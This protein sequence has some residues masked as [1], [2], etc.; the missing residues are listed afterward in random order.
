MPI[1]LNNMKLILT[2]VTTDGVHAADGTLH[3]IYDHQRTPLGEVL[4]ATF[5]EEDVRAGKS[6]SGK[7]RLR[8]LIDRLPSTTQ[9]TNRVTDK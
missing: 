2:L 8:A 6:V 1:D 3:I 4:M 9:P 5:R 7:V